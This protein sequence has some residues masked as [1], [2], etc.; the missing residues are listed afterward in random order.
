MDGNSRRCIDS[1]S[2]SWAWDTYQWAGGPFA[3]YMPG[4]FARMHRHV[5]APE[6][7]IHFAGEHCSRSHSWMQGALESA[8]DAVKVLLAP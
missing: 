2:D 1:A 4:Q 6:G 3:L 7:R 5:V 8:H